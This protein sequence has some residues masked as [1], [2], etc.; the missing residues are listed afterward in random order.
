MHGFEYPFFDLHRQ[1]RVH[2][3][4]M[5]SQSDLLDK[6]IH[7][8]MTP[9]QHFLHLSDIPSPEHLSRID[10]TELAVKFSRR[11]EIL[12]RQSPI[13]WHNARAD[14]RKDLYRS[15]NRPGAMWRSLCAQPR[16]DATSDV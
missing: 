13:G 5:Q 8:I 15:R 2:L 10:V 3:A 16:I 1:V 14:K 11:G 6:L 4:A 7:F 12:D 9:A